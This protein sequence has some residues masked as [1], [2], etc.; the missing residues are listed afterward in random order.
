MSIRTKRALKISLKKMLRKK[1]IFKITIRDITDD[2]GVNRMTFYYHFQ[3]I[4]ELIEWTWRDDV[5]IAFQG[6]DTYD[7][8]WQGYS[9]VFQSLLE[10]KEV[11]K[12]LYK[13]DYLENIKQSMYAF[14]YNL[15]IEL[16]EERAADMEI[17]MEDKKFIAEFYKYAFVGIVL[18][19]IRD[20]MKKD[21][22]QIIKRLNILMEGNVKK[23]VKAYKV[24]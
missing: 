5:G 17:P 11:I 12:N 18:D 6:M 22:E 8:W 13:E 10:D 24:E 14:T 1:S 23:A 3:D 15:M 21:P 4:Y 16:V 20:G 9:K 19:W 2:C 7:M